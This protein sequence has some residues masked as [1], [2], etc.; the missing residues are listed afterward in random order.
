M[1]RNALEDLVGGALLRGGQHLS[2]DPL[3]T[4]PLEQLDEPGSDDVAL[5][6]GKRGGDVEYAHDAKYIGTPMRNP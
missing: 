6:A 3:S 2:I 1:D 5:L 4:Q